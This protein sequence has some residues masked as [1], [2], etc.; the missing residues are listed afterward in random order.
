MIPLTFCN[1][2]LENDI[3]LEFLVEEMN[4]PK[5]VVIYVEKGVIFVHKGHFFPLR[6]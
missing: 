5:H 1:V 2:E 4:V 3:E 6:V